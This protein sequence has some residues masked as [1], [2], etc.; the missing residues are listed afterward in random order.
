MALTPRFHFCLFHRFGFSISLCLKKMVQ[1]LLKRLLSLKTARPSS[2]RT[3]AQL[4]NTQLQTASSSPVHP[5]ITSATGAR[6]GFCKRLVNGGKKEKEGREDTWESHL[7]PLF[8]PTPWEAPHR[9]TEAGS[10]LGGRRSPAPH[11]AS[12]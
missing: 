9:H 7:L 3:N 6:Q 1:L 11:W 4:R 5:V 8:Q 10:S 2:L 12:V